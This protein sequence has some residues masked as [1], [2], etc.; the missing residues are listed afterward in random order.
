M[1]FDKIKIKQ[2]PLEDLLKLKSR[3]NEEQQNIRLM[4]EFVDRRISS[5]KSDR[6]SDVSF[7]L[8][9]L[10]DDVDHFKNHEYDFGQ[11]YDLE[12]FPLPSTSL[13]NSP[14]LKALNKKFGKKEVKE[15]RDLFAN[16]EDNIS[17][18]NFLLDDEYFIEGLFDSH[19][20]VINDKIVPELS[21]LIEQMIE[22]IE[23]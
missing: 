22:K 1:Q 3:L 19:V 21:N 7:I 13:Y 8:A 16:L 11:G 4:S 6:L 15:L 12:R 14:S 9:S 10:K 5:I 18:I 23:E 20:E 17:S 2:M